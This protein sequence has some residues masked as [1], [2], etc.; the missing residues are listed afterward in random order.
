[1][2]DQREIQIQSKIFDFALS[3]LVLNHRDTF[4][5]LWTIDSWVKFLIWMA[6]N[7]GLSGDKNSL[8]L[9]AEAMGR[10]LTIRMRNL[11]FERILEDQAIKILADPSESKVLVMPLTS[12]ASF[13]KEQVA[14][15]LLQVG[16]AEKIVLDQS[17]W[18]VLHAVIAVPWNCS[19]FSS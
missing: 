3:E 11:F 8:E 4:Q 2:Q 17:R 10:P 12:G 15:A 9:F 18:Q 1:M 7:C 6:L 13:T 16:L 5:P 19:D 14:K